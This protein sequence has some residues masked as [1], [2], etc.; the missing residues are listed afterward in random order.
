MKHFNVIRLI[1]AS[2]VALSTQLATVAAQTVTVVE[3]HNKSLDAYFLTGR[4]AEQQLLD[5]VADF[6]R[7]GMSFKAIAAATA[8]AARTKI[9]RFYVTLTSPF[10]N[11]HFYGKQGTDCESI[12][13]ANPAGFHNEGFDF[14]VQSSTPGIGAAAD[15]GVKLTVE[16]VC[17]NGLTAVR[18]GFRAL[19]IGTGK[20]SNHRYTVSTATAASAAAAGYVLE[21]VQFCVDLWTDVNVA[22]VQAAPQT[23]VGVGASFS[24]ILSAS[25]EVTWKLQSY[26]DNVATYS[27]SR[28]ASVIL[29]GCPFYAPDNGVINVN[30]GVLVV[31]YNSFPPTYRGS[32]VT[33]WPSILNTS[34]CPPLSPPSFST[35]ANAAYFGGTKGMLGV[36]AQG[37][38]SADGL[39][40]EGADTNTS[41]PEPVTFNWYFSRK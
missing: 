6:S 37:L 12:L 3:Y 36:E 2:I 31:D 17:P 26:I 38:V 23:W 7:T 9:C 4:V 39:T 41:G 32:A 8:P 10:V 35:F 5:T 27:P 11:S 20:T 19:N 33:Q 13:A 29:K 16:E 40:I 25:A 34:N 24:S 1:F 18:R 14:A 28:T 30:A 15:D 22:P 21:G